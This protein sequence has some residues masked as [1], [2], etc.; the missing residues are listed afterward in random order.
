[1]TANVP[2]E[3]L[4]QCLYTINIGSNDYLNNYFMQGDKYNTQR[5]YTY[6]QFA[7]SLIRHYRSLLKVI[8]PKVLKRKLIKEL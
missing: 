5:K 2:P 8:L 6:D 7:D 3:K 1:M 4:K